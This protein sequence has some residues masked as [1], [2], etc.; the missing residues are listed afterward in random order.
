MNATIQARADYRSRFGSYRYRVEI[1]DGADS[2]DTENIR[3]FEITPEGAVMSYEAQDENV[4]QPIIPS[5]CR[6]TFI[7][8]T[9]DQI[10]FLRTVATAA[11][12]RYGVRILRSNGTGT[13]ISV[14]WVGTLI[15]DQFTFSDKLPLHVDMIASD[16]LGYLKEEPYTDSNNVRY[17]GSATV[18]E[19]ILNCINKLRTKWHWGYS[20]TIMGNQLFNG[21]L[22]YSDDIRSNTFNTSGQSGNIFDYTKI[23]HMAFYTDDEHRVE[24]AYNVLKDILLFFNCQIHVTHDLSIAH[25]FVVIPFG[26]FQKYAADGTAVQNGKFIRANGANYTG[27]QAN[28]ATI[29]IGSTGSDLRLQGGNFGYIQPYKKITRENNLEGGP[30]HLFSKQ[31]DEEQSGA[32]LNGITMSDGNE[33][34]AIYKFNQDYTLPSLIFEEG[35]QFRLRIDLFS[36]FNASSAADYPAL[37][38]STAASFAGAMP[39]AFNIFRMRI[40][41]QMRLKDSD[42]N[43][44][45]LKRQLTASG[46]EVPVYVD[47]DGF[48][49]VP[50]YYT[51][52]YALEN[53]TWDTSG[54]AKYLDVISEP[55]DGNV[56]QYVQ[57][58]EDIITPPILSFGNSGVHEGVVFKMEVDLIAYD[59]T[60][61]SVSTS[62]NNYLFEDS[63][64]HNLNAQLR[65]YPFDGF[66][67]ENLE[68]YT[69]IN[70][71][72]ARKTF[73]AESPKHIG[74]FGNMFGSPRYLH[75]SG[76][77]Q[78]ETLAYTS[79]N[80]TDNTFPAA[81]ICA[82]E[83]ANYYSKHREKYNGTIKMGLVGASGPT[84]YKVISYDNSV[85]SGT[86]VIKSKIQS[87]RLITGFEESEV[88]IIELDRDK[89]FSSIDSNVKKD[90]K[91]DLVIFDPPS[92]PPSGILKT[93]VSNMG[94]KV[95]P[96]LD[97]T[98]EA[99]TRNRTSQTGAQVAT[100]DANGVIQE[101]T[102]GSNGQV[103][104]TNGSGVYSFINAGSGASV[105]MLASSSFRASMF[106]EN[107]YYYGSS[108]YGW[109]IDTSFTT[110][111]STLVSGGLSDDHAHNLIIIPADLDRLV[112]RSSIRN[113]TSAVD[114]KVFIYKASRPNGATS[115]LTVTQIGT[116]TAACSGGVNSHYNCD[117][118]M[119][120][121]SI[122]AGEGILLTLRRES[123]GNTSTL[124]NVTYSLLAIV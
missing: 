104:S 68:T 118:D 24:N 117:I 40:R 71:D 108:V 124:V 5:T 64:N 106:Y 88:T 3:A 61:L 31:F 107:R 111:S 78:Y 32:L 21:T 33:N 2:P 9:T 103:L 79:I 53:S 67:S 23:R 16:D 91:G 8:T 112:F 6:F 46:G 49:S 70:N 41:L 69:V 93:L 105:Y 72:D 36:Y 10:A 86:E 39:E 45:Y 55:F 59:G 76:T 56:S 57:F 30:S 100:I 74:D 25:S 123:G 75:S 85:S 54:S 18:T 65:V 43:D 97:L 13:P 96:T 51:D 120:G 1:V 82:Q 34:A 27:Y 95:A 20:I 84:L 109:S 22:Q 114:I 115:N 81:K 66:D 73:R 92:P 116:G 14:H 44:H 80:E 121:L 90:D 26:A 102:D 89:N 12:G 47:F 42:T 29:D 122:S 77:Y 110:S 94:V 58:S 87:L 48:T 60:V 101:V 63:H 113:D 50:Q 83:I 35:E 99:V 4:F 38:H 98:A 119:T 17:T 7:C 11:A 15:S 62:G 52:L 37:V 19:H 28:F